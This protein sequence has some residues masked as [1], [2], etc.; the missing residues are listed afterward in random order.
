MQAPLLLSILFLAILPGA[1]A[2][3]PTCVPVGVAYAC[4]GDVHASEGS[5]EGAGYAYGYDTVIVYS[6]AGLVAV[7]AGHS[8][9]ASPTFTQEG[10]SISADVF[11]PIVAVQFHWA[12]Y[13]QTDASGTHSSCTMQV[14][15]GSSLGWNTF[16][17][18]C[19]AGEP[20]NPGWGELI[21]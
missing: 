14:V 3:A 20:P 15:V 7:Y 8:C 18:P 19:T 13:E 4:A 9:Y 10:T 5:C 17:D 1:S 16:S 12:A 2:A 21:P 11:T 6:P